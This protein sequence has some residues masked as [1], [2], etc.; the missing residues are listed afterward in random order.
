MLRNITLFTK[1]VWLVCEWVS[2]EE[3]GRL[4]RTALVLGKRMKSSVIVRPPYCT[5]QCL[6]PHTVTVRPGWLFLNYKIWPSQTSNLNPV[7]NHVMVLVCDT[8]NTAKYNF[9]LEFLVWF[10]F[11]PLVSGFAFHLS[12]SCHCIN[13]LKIG[14]Y[15]QLEYFVVR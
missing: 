5:G 11:Q 1:S 10:L 6:P 8:T 15:F 7:G 13:K 2:G 12:L 9:H 14:L 3:G 4:C